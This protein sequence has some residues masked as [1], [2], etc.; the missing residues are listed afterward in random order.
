MPKQENEIREGDSQETP[1]QKEVSDALRKIAE[2]E[3][4]S[5]SKTETEK[6]DY[7]TE[8]GKIERQYSYTERKREIESTF[9]KREKKIKEL[10]GEIFGEDLPGS[11]EQER[12]EAMSGITAFEM[13]LKKT[14]EDLEKSP[15]IMAS[16]ER[17][18]AERRGILSSML[19]RKKKL[20]FSPEQNLALQLDAKRN[21][22][23]AEREE[24]LVDL[25]KSIG[26][27]EEQKRKALAELWQRVQENRGERISEI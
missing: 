24:A 12:D 26:D 4:S 9:E 21:Q 5:D 3:T 11:A 27:L 7:E 17:R 20:K 14:R 15:E 1:E 18:M 10:I 23:V 13:T 22:V 19:L 8:A 25:E 2:Q 16:D 6:I